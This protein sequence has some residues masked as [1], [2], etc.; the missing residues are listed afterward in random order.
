M[1]LLRKTKSFSTDDIQ[2]VQPQ[3]PQ[4]Q[5]QQTSKSLMIEQM[6]MQRQLLI[7]QRHRQ[8]LQQEEAAARSRE[9]MN[10]QKMAMKREMQ[11]DRQIAKIGQNNNSGVSGNLSLFKPKAQTT[12]PVSMK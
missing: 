6:K 5:P 8:K 2:Q 3:Q 1:I 10:Q 9:L 4:A 12:Q 7:T 11:E